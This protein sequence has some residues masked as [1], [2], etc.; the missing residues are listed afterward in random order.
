MFIESV[1]VFLDGLVEEGHGG[2]DEE[3]VD[4]ECPLELGQPEVDEEARLQDPVAGEDTRPSSHHGVNQVDGRVGAPVDE[5]LGVVVLAL[6]ADGLVAGVGR[7]GEADQ[8]AHYPG[9]VAEH[10]VGGEDRQQT[11]GEVDSS[12]PGGLLQGQEGRRDRRVL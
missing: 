9:S 1:A 2:V 5:P 10:E 11:V 12:Q 8:V 3:R 4:E 6:R 7:V